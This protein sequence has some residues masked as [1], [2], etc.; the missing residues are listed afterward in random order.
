MH[1]NDTIPIVARVGAWRVVTPDGHHDV[2]MLL[3]HY[4]YRAQCPTG[5]WYCSMEP[6]L[7]VM[8]VA[9][10]MRWAVC[11]ILSPLD[12]ARSGIAGGNS[13]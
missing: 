6:R 1:P 13:E 2:P 10:K 9:L 12:K 7:A 8:A 4:E 3:D 5:R 11:A